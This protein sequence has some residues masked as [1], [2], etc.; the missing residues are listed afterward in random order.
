M[1]TPIATYK[2]RSADV[3]VPARTPWNQTVTKVTSAKR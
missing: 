1:P 2:I 3:S